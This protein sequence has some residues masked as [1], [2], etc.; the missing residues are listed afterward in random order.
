MYVGSSYYEFPGDDQPTEL[1]GQFYFKTS[2][3]YVWHSIANKSVLENFA[4]KVIREFGRV[5]FLINNAPPA[6]D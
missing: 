6:I 4:T 1:W 2:P 3:N 5:D